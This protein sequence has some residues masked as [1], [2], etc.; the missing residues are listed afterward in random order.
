VSMIRS[1]LGLPIEPHDVAHNEEG[2]KRFKTL[3]ESLELLKLVEDAP[4]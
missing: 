4:K 3:F 1:L 2:L